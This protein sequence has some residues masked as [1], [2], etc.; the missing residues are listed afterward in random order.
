MQNGLYLFCEGDYPLAVL[1]NDAGQS[2]DPKAGPQ[3]YDLSSEPGEEH[4][5][6]RKEP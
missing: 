4:D 3:L 1:L 2:W 6:A 5:L